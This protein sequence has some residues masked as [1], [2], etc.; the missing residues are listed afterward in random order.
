M[1]SPMPRNKIIMVR[2]K[3]SAPIE[4]PRIAIIF[5]EGEDFPFFIMLSSIIPIITGIIPKKPA[6]QHQKRTRVN[7]P[8]T[9]VIIDKTLEF[10]SAGFNGEGGGGGC[11]PVGGGGTNESA[12]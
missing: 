6:Q 1:L 9:K 2:I 12:I 10:P 8:L 3:A 11:T 5:P 4:S 7:I